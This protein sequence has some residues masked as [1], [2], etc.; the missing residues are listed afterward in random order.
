MLSWIAVISLVLRSRVIG[1]VAENYLDIVG[2]VFTYKVAGPGLLSAVLY[3][4][5]SGSLLFSEMS[6]RKRG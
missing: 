4:V 2:R 6:L 3:V 5:F 1:Q